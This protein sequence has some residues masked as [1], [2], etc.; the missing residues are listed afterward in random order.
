M[1]D[2]PA[3]ILSDLDEALRVAALRA[4]SNQ[5]YGRQPRAMTELTGER[6]VAVSKIRDVIR[7]EIQKCC[8]DVLAPAV[9][10]AI[11]EIAREVEARFET[12]LAALEGRQPGVTDGNTSRDQVSS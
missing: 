4:H 10:Q 12:K 9:G 2:Q 1:L 7:R 8:D 11:G 6:F 3:C 5:L